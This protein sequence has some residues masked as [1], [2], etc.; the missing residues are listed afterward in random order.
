MGIWCA[1]TN[2]LLLHYNYT[3]CGQYIYDVH[4][5]GDGEWGL[6]ICHVFVDSIA[7]KKIDVLFIFADGVG[8]HK[9]GNFM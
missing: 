4:T 6:E 9:I 2:A 3:S 8:S 5:K 7:Y 1:T